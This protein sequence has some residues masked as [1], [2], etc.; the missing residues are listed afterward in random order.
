MFPGDLLWSL[1]SQRFLLHDVKDRLNKG[2]VT[3]RSTWG[4]EHQNLKK[5]KKILNLLFIERRGNTAQQ[6]RALAPG[7]FTKE[8]HFHNIAHD[9][10]KAN[11][12][13]HVIKIMF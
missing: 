1:R 9:L 2:Q 7:V 3:V 8:K 6:N 13:I 11:I 4:T 5:A 12:L 10:H